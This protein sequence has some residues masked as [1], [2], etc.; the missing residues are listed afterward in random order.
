MGA[1]SP[2]PFVSKE[3]EDEIVNNILKPTI[4][5]FQNEGIKYKG[6]LYAGLILTEMGPKVLE[7]NARLGDPETQVLLPRLEDDLLD[8]MLKVVNEDL[9]GVEINISDKAAVCVVLSSGGYPLTY[10]KGKEIEGLE[11]LM[12]YDNVLV[13]HAGTK[14]KGDHFVTDGGRVLGITVLEDGLFN[15]VNEAYEMVEMVQFEDMHYRTDIG[16]DAA[17]YE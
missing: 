8:L 10:K 2:T 5:A 12:H 7:F 6:I 3:M 17:Q 16:F 13:F 1:Y 11:N 9:D 14:K 15:T 4:K